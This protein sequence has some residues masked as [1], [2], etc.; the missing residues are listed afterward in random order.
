MHFL[1]AA[2][3]WP[4]VPDLQ[5]GQST[6]L[7]KEKFSSANCANALGLQKMPEISGIGPD[8]CVPLQHYYTPQ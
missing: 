7:Q 3:R 6:Q 4:L 1:A 8:A 2:I 5:N